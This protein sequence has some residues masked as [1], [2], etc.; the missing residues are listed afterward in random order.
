MPSG[1]GNQQNVREVEPLFMYKIHSWWR[2]EKCDIVFSEEPQ[3]AWFARWATCKDSTSKDPFS[4][5][6]QLQGI[7]NS[8]TCEKWI[9]GNTDYDWIN[10]TKQSDKH[11]NM[12]NVAANLKHVNTHENNNWRLVSALC[13]SIVSLL[14]CHCFP[15]PLNDSL[16]THSGSS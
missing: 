9:R 6:K 16:C 7:T 10:D 2:E 13:L 14:S 1:E 15:C 11:N 8:H 12:F 4:Q 3:V 5:C